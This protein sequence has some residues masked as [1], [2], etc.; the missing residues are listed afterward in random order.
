MNKLTTNKAPDWGT[1]VT[2][3]ISDAAN[4]SDA[5]AVQDAVPA[6]QNH[7]YNVK[8]QRPQ[9]TGVLNSAF[10]T[11]E[12]GGKLLGFGWLLTAVLGVIPFI[13]QLSAVAPWLMD[14]MNSNDFLGGVF[15]LLVIVTSI[16]VTY[17]FFS[18]LDKGLE[19]LR[20]SKYDAEIDIYVSRFMKPLFEK[21]GYDVDDY[22]LAEAAKRG[23]TY[24]VGRADGLSRI[25]L[26]DRHVTITV[27][28][29]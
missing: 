2:E 13:F 25:R 3:T 18:Q 28:T 24:L 8:E 16:A 20:E 6:K 21:I 5:P 14:F 9:P 10:L 29:L 23:D 22:K 4:V 26:F 15:S 12:L 7:I 17:P 1:V 27:K 19:S 11:G